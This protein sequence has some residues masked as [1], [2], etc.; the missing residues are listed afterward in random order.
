MPARAGCQ[1]GPA[2][3]A[4]D[5]A[6]R[7]AGGNRHDRQRRVGTALGRQHAA[8]GDVEVGYGE[9]AAVAVDYARPAV[10]GH[11]GAADEVRIAIDCDHLV[12]ARGTQDVFHY[13]PGRAH[14]VLIVIAPGVREPGD[15]HA[16]LIGLVSERHPVLRP[17]QAPEH[18]AG[19]RRIPGT[20]L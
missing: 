13:L 1:A 17:G 15:R 20:G 11:P 4:G 12:G 18:H 14:E 16:T 9:A 5:Q 10:S 8:V 19:G 2:A 7:R 6:V 3:G